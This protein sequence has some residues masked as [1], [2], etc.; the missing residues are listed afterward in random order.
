[1]M[2][3]YFAYFDQHFGYQFLNPSNQFHFYFILL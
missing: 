1:M 2:C 3:L